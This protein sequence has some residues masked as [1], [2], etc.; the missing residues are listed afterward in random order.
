MVVLL[1]LF[2]ECKLGYWHAPPHLNY[3]QGKVQR[4][5]RTFPGFPVNKKDALCGSRW[6]ER[7]ESKSLVLQGPAYEWFIMCY[8]FPWIVLEDRSVPVCP[9]PKSDIKMLSHR[10]K[11]TQ[12]KNHALNT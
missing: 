3:A 5:E 9:L 12:A 4:T 10:Q 6:N 8:L 2:P 1:L 7:G 11:V